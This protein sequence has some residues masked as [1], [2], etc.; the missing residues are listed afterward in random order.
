M[1]TKG[2]THGLI[3][4]SIRMAAR[5]VNNAK[6][7]TLRIVKAN[8]KLREVLENIDEARMDWES[9][10]LDRKGILQQQI[11]AARAEL[12]SFDNICDERV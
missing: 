8:N 7:M 10:V 5:N 11:S 1:N 2:D 6:A 4:D 3:L 12:A 9:F